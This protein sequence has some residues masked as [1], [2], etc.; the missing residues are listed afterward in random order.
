VK[1]E[2]VMSVNDRES[3]KISD[4]SDDRERKFYHKSVH[5]ITDPASSRGARV[6]KRVPFGIEFYSSADYIEVNTG[7]RED[8]FWG[9]RNLLINDKENPEI[10]FVVCKTCGK[11]TE[12]QLT[13]FELDKHIRAYHFGYCVH[14]NSEYEG[15]KDD[16]FNELYIYRSFQTEAL[17]ILLPVQDFRTSEKVSIFKAGLLLGLKNYYKGHPDHVHIREYEE[18]NSASGRKERFLVMYES[19]PG[20]T[21]YLSRLFNTEEFTK[22]LTIAYD[23]IKHCTCKDEGKDGCYKCIYTYANQYD[24]EVLSR[25][26]AEILFRDI[27]EKSNEWNEVNSLTNL[28]HIAN[29]EESELEERFVQLLKDEYK[30]KPHSEFEEIT[31]NGYRKYRLILK[32]SGNSVCY[33]IWPQNLGNSLAGVKY[34]TRPDFVFKCVSWI[35]EGESQSFEKILEIKDIVLYLDG[36]QFHATKENKRVSGDLKIRDAITRSGRY[37]QWIFSWEDIINATTSKSED[38][39]QQEMDIETLAKVSSKISALKSFDFTKIKKN[40]SFLRFK[41]LLNQPLLNLDLKLWSAIQ[42]FTCQTKILSKC[43]APEKVDLFLTSGNELDF[44][45]LPGSPDQFSFC[46]NLKFTDELKIVCL[47]KLKGFEIKWG[48]IHNIPEGDYTKENWELFWQTYNLQQFHGYCGT[49]QEVSTQPE[50]IDQI[51]EN[52]RPE[53]HSIVKKLIGKNIAINKEYDFDILEDD[54]I[55]AQAELGSESHRFFMH[56]FSDESRSKFAELGYQEFTV[57]NF[58]IKKILL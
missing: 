19:I 15:K 55:V 23:H 28:T 33:E 43:L 22:L 53:L 56:P 4:S 58:N 52:F 37:F 3:S 12:K 18:F 27:I 14:R 32:E 17:K 7:I 11:A 31:E 25:N 9:N 8:G 50:S 1:L 45:F 36:F 2:G 21:G 34:T 30:S 57:D 42:L 47:A 29:D 10:G 49:E 6:L 44:E 13:R 20:G 41:I 16:I 48:I 51:L 38:L 40:N 26:E 46:D 35:I 24:R 5:L 54:V 39:L